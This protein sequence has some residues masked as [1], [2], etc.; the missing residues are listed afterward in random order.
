MGKKLQVRK[1]DRR[2]YVV[3]DMSV[4]NIPNKIFIIY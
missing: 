2:S 3:T 4:I 1:L